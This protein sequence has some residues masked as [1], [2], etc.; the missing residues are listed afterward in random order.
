MLRST[1]LAALLVALSVP[2][3]AASGTASSTPPISVTIVQNGRFDEDRVRGTF[4]ATAPMCATGRIEDVSHFD[5]GPTTVIAHRAHICGDGSGVLT[6]VLRGKAEHFDGT[7]TWEIERA[8]GALTTLR[9]RGTYRN[10]ATGEITF[11]NTWTGIVAF[12]DVAP[13]VEILRV[14]TRRTGSRLSLRLQ[15]SVRDDVEANASTYVLVVEN[16]ASGRR[17]ARRSG[18]IDGVASTEFSLRAPQSV[19]KLVL[20]LTATDPLG[21]ERVTTRTVRLPRAA[22]G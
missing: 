19:R 10:A 1:P 21:N 2:A 11:M 18:R 3:L 8:S 22:R 12:D 15:M 7:G 14:T 13:T 6:F 16:P 5:S 17:V 20:R 9:G 4:D